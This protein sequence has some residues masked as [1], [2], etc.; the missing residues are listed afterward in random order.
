M[1][2]NHA[3]QRLTQNNHPYGFT[4]IELLVV[5]LIIGI[6]TS[7]ALPQYQ[8]AV[9]K[10]RISE[11]LQIASEL[12]QAVDLYVTA[13]G[14]IRIE[15][16][17]GRAGLG[18]PLDIDIEGNFN[19]SLGNKDLCFS[20]NFGYDAFCNPNDYPPDQNCSIR[21]FRLKNKNEFLGN[22]NIWNI[23]SYCI[24]WRRD[25]TSGEWKQICQ[26]G[27]AATGIEKKL[28]SELNNP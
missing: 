20:N 25:S 9:E 27:P 1:T 12:R 5:I 4:L 26:R 7:V 21:A 28:C 23:H 15:L 3:Q 19:C 2:L 16:I 17:D 6:L 11:A 18:S 24:E 22:T 14:I 10:A 13:N 8:K